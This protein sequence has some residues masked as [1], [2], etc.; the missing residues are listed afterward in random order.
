MA[1][2]RNRW[3]QC[4][5]IGGR[6]LPDVIFKTVCVKQNFKCVLSLWN[7]NNFFIIYNTCFIVFWKKD[8]HIFPYLCDHAHILPYLGYC[9]VCCIIWNPRE[10]HITIA[11]RGSSLFQVS[12]LHPPQC[13][14]CC[15]GFSMKTPRTITALS[16]WEDQNG[17][18][19]LCCPCA[20]TPTSSPFCLIVN[21]SWILLCRI[22]YCN[23]FCIA[24]F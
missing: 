24:Y 17:C 9:I 23:I 10:H 1:N 3:I 18:R 7:K 2:I 11:L 4:M 12:R 8:A 14:G 20:P 15:N 5:D 19:C 16:Y 6:H 21:Y 22:K 13:L